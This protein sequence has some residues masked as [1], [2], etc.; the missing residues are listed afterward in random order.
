VPTI[1]SR[2]G[3]MAQHSEDNSLGELCFIFWAPLFW[4]RT[5]PCT[6]SVGYPSWAV[7]WTKVNFSRKQKFTVLE[8]GAQLQKPTSESLS[9]CLMGFFLLWGWDLGPYGAQFTNVD[10]GNEEG[11]PKLRGWV[12]AHPEPQQCVL[13]AVFSQNHRMVGLE[14]TSRLT[15]L[16]PPTTGRATNLHISYQPRLPRAPSNPALNTSRDGWGIHSLCG[17]LFQPLTTLIAKN[18]PHS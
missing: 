16:Q 6:G 11:P 10:M 13:P 12:F 1:A 14:G 3:R 9:R 15:Q 4:L 18:F 7:V 5:G 8:D 2:R 17:Q